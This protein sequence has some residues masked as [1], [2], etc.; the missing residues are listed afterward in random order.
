M[1]IEFIGKSLHAVICKRDRIG[2]KGVGFDDI[3]SSFQVLIMDLPDDLWLS[4]AEKIVVPL[5]IYL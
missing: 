1:K 5:Y 2:V 4:Q 3:S